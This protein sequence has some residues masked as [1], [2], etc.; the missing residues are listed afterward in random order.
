MGEPPHVDDPRSP[1][2]PTRRDRHLTRPRGAHGAQREV[3]R[4]L[5]GASGCPRVHILLRPYI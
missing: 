2:T 3:E 4:P 1:H 5:A